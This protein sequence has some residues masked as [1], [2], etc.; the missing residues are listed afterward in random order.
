M[1]AI[2]GMG[3]GRKVLEISCTF[4]FFSKMVTPSRRARLEALSLGSICTFFFT[5]SG[6]GVPILRFLRGLMI[7]TLRGAPL[8]FLWAG[9]RPLVMCFQVFPL[10]AKIFSLSLAK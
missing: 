3:V 8:L 10:C 6:K 7:F 1:G 4:Y 9:P 5:F 2:N